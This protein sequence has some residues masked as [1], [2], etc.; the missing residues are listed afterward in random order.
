MKESE[1]SEHIVWQD[2]MLAEAQ[3][4]NA[5]HDRIYAERDPPVVWPVAV[6]ALA[7][8]VVLFAATITVGRRLF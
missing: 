6:A 8:A 7:T 5:D 4:A 3:C 2:Q 1:W